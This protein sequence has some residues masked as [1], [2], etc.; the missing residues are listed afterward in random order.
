MFDRGHGETILLRGL[1]SPQYS[2]I[3]RNGN[4]S[5]DR[6]YH[7]FGGIP[8][9]GLIGALF[10]P[11]FPDYGGLSPECQTG[12]IKGRKTG[13][14]IPY[15][16]A[17]RCSDDLEQVNGQKTPVLLMPP[18]CDRTSFFSKNPGSLS[19]FIRQTSSR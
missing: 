6:A 1:M 4:R 19:R 8:V 18:L 17:D 3:A 12:D 2:N 13:L 15:W 11:V 9:T 14:I 5:S 7:F 16:E 10:C